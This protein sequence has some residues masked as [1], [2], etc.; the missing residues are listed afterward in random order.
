MQFGPGVAQWKLLSEFNL[1]RHK[2]NIT[3][4]SY[5]AQMKLHRFSIINLI[6]NM[7]DIKYRPNKHYNFNLTH[8]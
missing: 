1:G 5:E 3:P 8:F 4:T 2:S 7:H 6:V